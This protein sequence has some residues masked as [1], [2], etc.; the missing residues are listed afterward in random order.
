MIR[1][2]RVFAVSAL[3]LVVAAPVVAIEITPP[4]IGDTEVEVTDF[5]LPEAFAGSTKRANLNAGF[6]T[7]IYAHFDGILTTNTV[8]MLSPEEVAAVVSLYSAVA[9]QDLLVAVDVW[10]GETDSV[11]VG[12]T[13]TDA[14]FTV[15]GFEAGSTEIVISGL[16]P[17]A[18]V[19]SVY[20]PPGSWP[21]WT[22]LTEGSWPDLD[23]EAN[24]E[25]VMPPPRWRG[26]EYVLP[27]EIWVLSLEG[28]QS[29]AAVTLESTGTLTR[30]VV[31]AVSH[32]IGASGVPFISDLTLS[33]PM[34]FP[35]SGWIRFVEDGGS[36]ETAPSVDFEL[37]AGGSTTWTD[38]LQSAFGIS[39]NVK[40]SLIVGGYRHWLLQVSSRNYAVDAE[41][42]RFGI[43]LPGT[44]TLAPVIGPNPWQLPG[45][46]QND[47][48]RTNLLLA[49][50]SA[51][52]STVTIRI[53]EDGVVKAEATRDVPPYEL[54]QI[55]R[56]AL[57]LG[58]GPIEDGFIELTVE[59]GGVAAA[60]SVVDGSAD[61]A[62]YI[63]ARPM[64]P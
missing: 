37:G 10:S 47:E 51:E 54:V 64:F 6:V 44:P 30:H 23:G 35:V 22:T 60:I 55:N 29:P 58:A 42:R 25:F 36:L 27:G 17:G 16:E 49:G 59:S 56:V 62:A 9:A 41:D 48:Y 28:E 1:T 46:V 3:V 50:A 38:V 53:I 61:D 21:I 24:G 4:E 40:G 32:I 52:T 57:T 34:G 26:P 20:T 43:A 33:N 12:K 5:I 31:P 39:S 63:V 7:L 18:K 13:A 45:L 15:E 2:A 14:P 11:T 19:L 8:F